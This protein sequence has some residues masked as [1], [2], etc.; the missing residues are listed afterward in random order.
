MSAKTLHIEKVAEGTSMTRWRVTEAGTA[1]KPGRA[2]LAS[3]YPESEQVFV[4]SAETERAVKNK[5][6]VDAVRAHITANSQPAETASNADTNRVV[7]PSEAE[8]TKAIEDFL[9]AELGEIPP[10]SLCED[11]DPEDG[12]KC[13][14]AFW[15]TEDGCEGDSTSY[16]SNDLRIQWLG[17]CWT[18]EL[19]DANAED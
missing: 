3:T 5:R 19:A 16:V 14:W 9:L 17:T 15:I 4:M 10:F 2:W 6:V 1:S 13:G 12:D 7:R 18:R 8:A 11:G